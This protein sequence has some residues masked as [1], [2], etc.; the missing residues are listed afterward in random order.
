M[1]EEF[2]PL[3]NKG[4]GAGIQVTAYTQTLSDIQARIGNAPKTGRW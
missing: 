2:I 1:G 3:V 4:G